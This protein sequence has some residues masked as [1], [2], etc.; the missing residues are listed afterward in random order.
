MDESI[1]YSLAPSKSDKLLPR[2]SGVFGRRGPPVGRLAIVGLLIVIAAAGLIGLALNNR[3]KSITDQALQYDIELEDRGDDFRVAV[4][5]MRHF[6]RNI[7]FAGPSRHGLA[8]FEAAYLFLHAQIDRLEALQ[9]PDADLVN[10]DTLRA[11]AEDYYTS[12]RPAIDRY[13]QDRQ[14]F[15]L[16]SDDGL[17][18]LAELEGHARELDQLG[19]QRSAEALRSVESSADAAEVVM[20]VVLGGLIFTGLGLAYLAARNLRQQQEAAAELAQ[21]LELRSVFIADASH[22]LRTP[23]TVLRANAELAVGAAEPEE[24]T[25]LL[26]E[27][28]R[29]SERMTRLVEDL[30]FLASSDSESSLLQL[31]TVSVA[32]FLAGVTARSEALARRYGATIHSALAGDG[33]A[34]LDEARIEQ[35]ILILV[36]NAAKFGPP[37]GR[38]YLRSLV[39]NGELVVEVRD[40]GPGIPERELPFVFE[41][42]YQVDKARSRKKGGAGLG[43]AIARSIV[44]AHRG[45]I[46]AESVLGQGTVMRIRLPVADAAG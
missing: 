25:E 1:E 23:L 20:L 35:A 46:E 39:R 45:R 6:H 37:D 44:E 4:L 5:D 42:F 11:I 28:L 43:L 33:L 22:E 24:Q 3:V 8:D 19:E 14:G 12:F 40:R 31:E 17:V 27:I 18:R 16:A 21:A 26:D 41:R 32:P 30:L 34:H 13:D 36:D 7:T 15:V 10:A 9:Y 29:E 38:I 2:Q